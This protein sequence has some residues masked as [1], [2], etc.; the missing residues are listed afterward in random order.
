MDYVQIISFLY[1]SAVW[2]VDYVLTNESATSTPVISNWNTTKLGA[3]PT[4]AYLQSQW[5]NLVL[6]D[7][8]NIQIGILQDAYLKVAYQP[9]SYMGTSFPCTESVMLTLCS[10]LVQ[11]MTPQG[12]PSSFQWWDNNNNGVAMTMTQL[13]GLGN[14]FFAQIYPAFAKLQTYINQVKSATTVAEINAVVWS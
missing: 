9:I 4:V 12:L 5:N 7:A 10:T 8:R 14:L 6:Y 1:P 11:G 13:E 3:Q 2:G